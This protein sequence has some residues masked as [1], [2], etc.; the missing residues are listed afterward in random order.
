MM[1]DRDE[2]LTAVDVIRCAYLAHLAENRGDHE[3]ARRWQAKVETWLERT[4]AGPPE[5]GDTA[6]TLPF[7]PHQ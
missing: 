4:H 5:F 6:S 2:S 1:N 3:S 7:T